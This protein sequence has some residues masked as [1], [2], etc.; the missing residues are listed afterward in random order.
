M[1]LPPSVPSFISPRSFSALS[2]H[3]RRTEATKSPTSQAAQCWDTWVPVSHFMISSCC[4]IRLLSWSCH[5]ESSIRALVHPLFQC[6]STEQTDFFPLHSHSSSMPF[7][8]PLTDISPSPF[9]R[10][11]S[12]SWMRPKKLPYF[13]HTNTVHSLEHPDVKKIQLPSAQHGIVEPLQIYTANY[14]CNKLS[15]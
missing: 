8:P 9:S 3:G 2:V 12:A 5:Q 7:L 6:R 14:F 15:C 13:T 4:W 10:W 11:Y 1:H